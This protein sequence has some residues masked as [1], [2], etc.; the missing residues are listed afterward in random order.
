MIGTSILFPNS[1]PRRD[2]SSRVLNLFRRSSR[3][4]GCVRHERA[5]RAD[6]DPGQEQGAHAAVFPQSAGATGL[7]EG[8]NESLVSGAT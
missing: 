8:A 4:V 2:D 7:P 3:V 1:C 5:D 6:R